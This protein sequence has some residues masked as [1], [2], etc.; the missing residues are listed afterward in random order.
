MAQQHTDQINCF[1]WEIPSKLKVATSSN[2]NI[3][4]FNSWNLAKEG[5]DNTSQVKST[6]QWQL[7]SF[8]RGSDLSVADKS[9]KFVCTIHAIPATLQCNHVFDPNSLAWKPPTAESSLCCKQHQQIHQHTFC[10]CCNL[11]V[12]SSLHQIGLRQRR[13]TSPMTWSNLC[14]IWHA[15]YHHLNTIS[16]SDLHSMQWHFHWLE[17][18]A[19]NSLWLS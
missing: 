7:E 18:V 6:H 2:T 11:S 16:W 4:S 13:C 1:G 15:T 3:F 12:E 8:P 14:C 5:K 19:S 9:V 10:Q 17:H